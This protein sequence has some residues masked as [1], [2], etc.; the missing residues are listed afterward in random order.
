MA[1]VMIVQMLL[2]WFKLSFLYVIVMTTTVKAKNKDK[3]KRLPKTLWDDINDW[4]SI[5][6]IDVSILQD[7][8]NKICFGCKNKKNKFIQEPNP[9]NKKPSNYYEY[10]F[11]LPIGTNV[12]YFHLQ[13]YIKVRKCFGQ[14]DK[15]HLVL[16][17][18]HI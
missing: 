4:P 15:H 12:K 13:C 6:S 9:E 10:W 17:L 5:F 16:S 7:Q 2:P 3:P 18:I 11:V 1:L 8:S 14:I